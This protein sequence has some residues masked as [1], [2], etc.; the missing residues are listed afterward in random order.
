[1]IL[2][3]MRL[4]RFRYWV[5]PKIRRQYRTMSVADTFRTV[6]RKKGWGDDGGP[7][8]SGPGSRGPTAEEYCNFAIDF[9]RKHGV[10]SVVDLGCGDFAVGKRIV[11]ATG[12]RYTGIDVVPELIEYH[13]AVSTDP[14]VTFCCANIVSDPLPAADLYLIRQVLQHLSNDEIGSVLANLGNCSKALISE[15][16]PIVPKSFNRDKPHGPDIRWFLGSGVYIDKPP[17]SILVETTWEWPLGDDALMRTCLVDQ[18]AVTR[19]DHP[20]D[21]RKGM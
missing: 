1:M 6:Y 12:V 11:E 19:I 3:R 4:W 5:L 7:F 14:R 20:S 18:S 8:Y 2:K 13:Q 21:S 9:I 16:V 10:S 17:F 15:H